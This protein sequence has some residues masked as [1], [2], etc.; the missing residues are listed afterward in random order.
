MLTG[1]TDQ[2]FVEPPQT[3]SNY[4]FE[5]LR[6][7]ADATSVASA[8][9]VIQLSASGLQAELE[10]LLQVCSV[11]HSREKALA[12]GLACAEL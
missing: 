9:P 7:F 5:Y 3:Q 1:V 4:L 11:G 10:S 12:R 2:D 6:N 8:C